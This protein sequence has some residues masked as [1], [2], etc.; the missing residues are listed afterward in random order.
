MQNPI[1][2]YLLCGVAVPIAV[3]FLIHKKR[4]SS[5]FLEAII[6]GV[7]IGYLSFFGGYA[8][9]LFWLPQLGLYSFF[10]FRKT[11]PVKIK[12]S[13]LGLNAITSIAVYFLIWKSL[14]LF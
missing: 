2:W 7:S 9:P 12:I 14:A 5:P 10:L 1:N 6:L 3:F 4:T 13:C 11:W 8:A